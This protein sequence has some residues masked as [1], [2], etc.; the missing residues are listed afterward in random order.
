MKIKVGQ[1]FVRDIQGC[2]QSNTYMVCGIIKTD[3]PLAT[4]NTHIFTANEVNLIESKDVSETSDG[5][6]LDGIMAS[7]LWR[8]KIK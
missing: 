1:L 8:V 3:S 6:G 5:N 4:E 7:P 2:T